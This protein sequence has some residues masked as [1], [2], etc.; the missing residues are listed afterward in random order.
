[1]GQ[2]INSR[3]QGL[4]STT[5]ATQTMLDTVAIPLG[6]VASIESDIVI[7]N[8]TNGDSARVKKTAT[9]K[10]VAGT[11]TIIGS[12]IDLVALSTDVSLIGI[13]VA[14]GISGTN[15]QALVTGL[16]ATNVDWQSDTLIRIN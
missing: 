16:L 15:V 6:S 12:V 7:R 13:V 9:Y 3:Q 11:V 1:M 5:N 14:F 2:R 10:N 4:V 8:T